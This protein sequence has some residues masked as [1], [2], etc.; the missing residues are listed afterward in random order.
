ME[1][2]HELYT[3]YISV[4]LADHEIFRAKL[5]KGGIMVTKLALLFAKRETVFTILDLEVLL[6]SLVVQ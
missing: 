3:T 6:L 2:I 4:D 1:I 5:G